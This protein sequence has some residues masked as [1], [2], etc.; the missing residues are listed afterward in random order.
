M[1]V[2]L[3]STSYQAAVMPFYL[4]ESVLEECGK[5]VGVSKQSTHEMFPDDV[6]KRVVAKFFFFGYAPEMSIEKNR[7]DGSYCG[8]IELLVGSCAMQ[9]GQEGALGWGGGFE[10]V[11]L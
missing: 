9:G 3:K 5:A 10:E 8:A 6:V 4:T 7:A 2:A 11:L 1:R